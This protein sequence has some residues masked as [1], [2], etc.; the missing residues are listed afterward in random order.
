MKHLES[1]WKKGREFLGVKVMSFASTESM[2]KRLIDMEKFWMGALGKAVKDGDVDY[3]SVM[4]GQSVG[5]VDKI[6]PLKEALD[7]LIR[8]ADLELGHIRKKCQDF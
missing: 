2:A 5:L 8:K 6:R 3:G 4:A 1:I 7:L